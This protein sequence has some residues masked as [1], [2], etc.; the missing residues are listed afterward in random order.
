M[1]ADFRE[2]L[3]WGKVFERI[4]A[5]EYA[6]LV[7]G[8][9]AVVVENPAKADADFTVAADGKLVA[10]LEVKARRARSTQYEDTIVVTR[11][12]DLGRYARMFF[13]VPTHC[14]LVF[15]DTVGMFRLDEKPDGKRMVTRQD[16]GTTGE[17]CYWGH[18]RME[19]FPELLAR[20][21]ERTG[22]NVFDEE[23]Q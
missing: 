8:A 11:K 21:E 23:V 3:D 9:G 15:E 7:W 14:V 6:K 22:V 17:H 20:I 18:K 10:F 1:P 4:A 16:R 5:E 19:W 13:Q 12:Y 2:E